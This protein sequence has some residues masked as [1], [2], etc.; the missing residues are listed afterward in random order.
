M[1]FSVRPNKYGQTDLFIQTPKFPLFLPRPASL[2]GKTGFTLDTTYL[3]AGE[4]NLLF[5]FEHECKKL[6]TDI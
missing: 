5:L 6:N 2:S 3:P 1:G 4:G